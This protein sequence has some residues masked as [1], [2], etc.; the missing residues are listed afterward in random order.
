MHGWVAINTNVTL[1]Q[2]LNKWEWA[3]TCT[4]QLL[5]LPYGDCRLLDRHYRIWNGSNKGKSILDCFLPPLSPLLS[6]AA[7]NVI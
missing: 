5:L 1:I 6:V 2:P 7:L 4:R 3:T